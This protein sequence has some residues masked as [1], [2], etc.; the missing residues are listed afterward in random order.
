MHAPKQPLPHTCMPPSRCLHAPARFPAPV[1]TYRHA[2]K[3]PLPRTCPPPS[4]RFQHAWR[5][6]PRCLKLTLCALSRWVV[7]P[8]RFVTLCGGP[9]ALCHAV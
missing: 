2:S 4:R 9:S 8:L 1:S 7:D 3:Q 6:R 5:G